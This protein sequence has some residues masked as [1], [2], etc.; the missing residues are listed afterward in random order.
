MIT[1]ILP[2][3]EGCIDTPSQVRNGFSVVL[4]LSECL[5]RHLL[6]WFS[7][8]DSSSVEGKSRSESERERKFLKIQE[9]IEIN[10]VV[11][12]ICG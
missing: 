9:S 8:A 12:L 4:A 5:N 11:P 7:P 10:K 6:H 2:R 3:Q 1:G